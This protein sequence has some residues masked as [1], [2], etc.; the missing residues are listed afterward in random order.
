MKQ[1]TQ[2]SIGIEEK[3]VGWLRAKLVHISNFFLRI[4]VPRWVV[5][6]LEMIIVVFSIKIAFYLISTINGDPFDFFKFGW[7]ELTIAGVQLIFFF[8]FRSYYGLIRYSSLRDAGRQFLVVAVAV[9]VLFV[10]NQ[11]HYFNTDTKLILSAGLAIYGVFTFSLLFLFQISVKELY[12]LGM[13]QR[14]V[15]MNYFIY[16]TD[17]EEV[18]IASALLL[19]ASKTYNLVGFITEFPGRAKNT[20]HNLPIYTPAELKRKNIEVEAII[21]GHNKLQKVRNKKGNPLNWLLKEGVRIYKIPRFSEWHDVSKTSFQ[22]LEEIN[23]E[24]LLPRFPI[25]LERRELYEIYTDKIILVTG[26][27]G[28]IGSEIVRQVIAF[29]P[30]KILL[31]DQA[32]TP[33]HNLTLEI[34]SE[35]PEIDFVSIIGDVR[36]EARME[37]LFQV[38]GPEAV[39]HAAAY[40]HVPLMETNFLEALSV[41]YRGTRNLAVLSGRYGV[42]R[43]V[44]VSTDKAVNPTNVM[45]ASKRSAEILIQFLSKRPDFKTNFITTRFGNV[46]GSNG[47]VVPLFQRQIAAGGPVTVTHPDINRFFMTIDEACQLVLIAAEMGHGG[48][49][50]VFDMGSPV[51]IDDLAKRM[52]RMAGLELGKDIEI[53]YTGLRPGEKLY[54]EVLADREK[55]LPTQQEKILIANGFSPLEA[56]KT[57]EVLTD[58]LEAIESHDCKTAYKLLQLMVPEYTP[59]RPQVMGGVVVE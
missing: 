8:V 49:I 53:K 19:R 52:I 5:L 21:I 15:R 25:N 10:I 50:F 37:R 41:N 3:I 14:R 51:K 24:D 2:S 17:P 23:V 55:T 35:H 39:F 30:R 20:I 11:V 36:D 47:S 54:E 45:G 4:Y 16:G 27:A 56:C 58:F 42:S 22:Q 28:S 40:K 38:Y 18:A 1:D 12:S 7:Q 9:G 31:V 34:R 44:F 29:K 46:L 32:E 6:L 48:E 59:D 26:A 57:E 43:F 13:G 33:M